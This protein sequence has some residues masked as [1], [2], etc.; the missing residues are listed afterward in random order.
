MAVQR[1]PDLPA[2]PDAVVEGLP[3]ARGWAGWV[4]FAGLLVILL[5]AFHVVEGLVAL[6]RGT[7]TAH[8][9][10]LSDATAWGWV[11]VA[12]GLVAFLVGVGLLAG[13]PVAR[14]LGVGLALVSAV[15][16]LAFDRAFPVGAAIVVVLDV[17]TVYAI[18]VHGGELRAPSS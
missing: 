4:M 12:L 5:G 18:T 15:V 2:T 14:V 1:P 17:V 6:L 8:A 13:R 9:L 11:H 10:V 7:G 3:A 16:N